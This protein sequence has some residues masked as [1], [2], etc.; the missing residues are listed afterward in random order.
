[1]II[2]PA[3]PPLRR[4]EDVR[5][6]VDEKLGDGVGVSIEEC[7]AKLNAVERVE[8]ILSN[9]LGSMYEKKLHIWVQG[10]CD[11]SRPDGPAAVSQL[12]EAGRRL[13]PLVADLIR[14]TGFRGVSRRGGLVT[15][16]PEVWYGTWNDVVPEFLT[17]LVERWPEGVDPIALPQ[18]PPWSRAEIAPASAGPRYPQVRLGLTGAGVDGVPE[19]APNREIDAACFALWRVGASDQELD[20]FFHEVRES[21]RDQSL[22]RVL[23]RWIPIDGRPADDAALERLRARLYPRHPLE[24]EAGAEKLEWPTL[25][26]LA[27]DR[28]EP[29]AAAL[30]DPG[31]IRIMPTAEISFEKCVGAALRQDPDILLVDARDLPESGVEILVRSLLTGHV[32]A[33]C[34]TSSAVESLRAKAAAAG[35]PTA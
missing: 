19:V 4:R 34:G 3:S 1:V 10:W 11:G 8:W 5:A 27:A 23:A 29:V 12:A 20:D 2:D 33:V 30:D 14:W 9:L 17:A 15:V 16:V 35:V 25:V 18:P 24:I 26:L 7:C 28:L 6:S 21:G 13:N 22:H 31:T 32:V